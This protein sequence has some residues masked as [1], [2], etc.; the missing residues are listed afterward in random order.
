M[1]HIIKARKD[2]SISTEKYVAEYQINDRI[3]PTIK[4]IDNYIYNESW[5]NCLNR[6]YVVGYGITHLDDFIDRYCKKRWAKQYAKQFTDAL[7]VPIYLHRSVDDACKVFIDYFQSCGF[8]CNIEIQEK[9]LLLD[10]VL[11]RLLIFT[12]DADIK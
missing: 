4:L 1:N 2:L 9:K 5:I 6:Y 12:I 8:K 11:R 10:Y 3:I 7:V